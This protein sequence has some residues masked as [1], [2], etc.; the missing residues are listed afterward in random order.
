MENCNM[1]LTEQ[2][3]N[4]ALSSGQI[5]KYEYLTVEE[6]LSSDQGR[7]I[8]PAKF[9]YSSSG[10]ALENKQKPWKIKARSK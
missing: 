10:K 9:T 1:I 3:Q 4:P 6:I 2:K 7:V 5:D 8:E